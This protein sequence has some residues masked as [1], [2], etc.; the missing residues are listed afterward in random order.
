M[1]REVIIAAATG[2]L[3]AAHAL[4]QENQENIEL[5]SAREAVHQGN[6][7]LK[8]GQAPAAL[9]AYE[10]AEG[11][12]PDAPEIQ[13]VKGLGHYALKEYDLAREAF[14]KAALSK[15]RALAEDA[16]YSVGTTYHA[17]ALDNAANTQIA[18]DKLES[19]LQRYQAVLSS[20]PDHLEARD[21]IV[22]AASMRRQ[23]KR[24]LE[25]QQQ[26]KQDNPNQD[27]Q[28]SENDQEQQSQ[29]GQDQ[30]RQDKQQRDSQ[31]RQAGEDSE[32]EQDQNEGEQEEEQQRGEKQS[33]ES[34]SPKQPEN[35]EQQQA[36]A[37]QAGEEER[38]TREQSERRLRE[39]M[40]NIRE[41]QKRRGKKARPLRI[42]PVDKDW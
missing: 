30:N 37:A 13:F 7:L 4:A 3:L 28:N 25:R 19:A 15:N 22:K 17:E 29:Q 27:K 1:R 31:Q 36:Q 16:T 23:L 38:I 21:A 6:L 20:R 18:I 26:Q 24:E 39:M 12:S 33:Q 10:H 8:S 2:A 14:E 40:Q 34:E 42:V 35:E 32:A 11:L 5:L 9:K 41:R